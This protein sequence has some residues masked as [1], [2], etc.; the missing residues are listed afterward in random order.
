M[1]TFT[2]SSLPAGVY[3]VTASYSGTTGFAGSASG[4]IVATAGDGTA[5]DSGDG[6]PATEAELNYEGGLALD[7]AGDLFI[8]DGNNALVREVVEATGNIIAV[9]GDGTQGYSGDGGPATDAELN[10]TNSVAIDSAGDLFMSD[11]G[12]HRIREV[13]KATGDIKTVA[14]TGTAGYSGDGGP[15][16]DAEIQGCCGLAVDSAGNLFIAD[17]NNNVVREVSAATGDITTFA[18]DGHAG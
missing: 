3:T 18:G 5:G 4:T 12:N 16:T 17:T 8:T 13:V 6:G 9:A 14:G 7:S 10:L 15:A 1:A 2:I 11:A